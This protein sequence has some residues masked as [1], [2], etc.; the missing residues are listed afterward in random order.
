VAK[1]NMMDIAAEVGK[2]GKDITSTSETPAGK[3]KI[4]VFEDPQNPQWTHVMRQ[5]ADGT[6][7]SKNGENSK[8]TGI[9]DPV[10]FYNKYFNEKNEA[11]PKLKTTYFLISPEKVK[12]AF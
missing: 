10:A 11:R 1:F 12:S 3:F 5:E 6:W 4:V 2:K 8:Y 7:S 9:K